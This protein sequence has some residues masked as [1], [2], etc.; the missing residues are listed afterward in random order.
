MQLNTKY[1]HIPFNGR[2]IMDKLKIASQ[3]SCSKDEGIKESLIGNINTLKMRI[4]ENTPEFKT[5]VIDYDYES[6]KNS[7]GDEFTYG[8]LSVIDN[9]NFSC[10]SKKV[11]LTKENK[12]KNEIEIADGQEI[13][14]KLFKNITTRII[15]KEYIP[16]DSSELSN[17][18]KEIYEKLN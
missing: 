16:M 13:W 10:K 6:K 4:Q 5:F 1:N 18:V 9:D 8:T 2:V 11:K 12:L 17:E 7:T 14:E 3:I 15:S